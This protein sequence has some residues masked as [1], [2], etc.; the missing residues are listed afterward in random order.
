MVISIF[1]KIFQT[2]DFGIKLEKT[3]ATDSELGFKVIVDKDTDISNAKL[4]LYKY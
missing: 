2:N 3:Y 4:A 1:K